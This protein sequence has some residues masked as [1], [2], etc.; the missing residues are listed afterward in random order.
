MWVDILGHLMCLTLR[1]MV[2]NTGSCLVGTLEG[3]NLYSVPLVLSLFFFSWKMAGALQFFFFL[4][5]SFFLT[6]SFR[7]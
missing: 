6:L 1:L 2:A 4:H 5:L 7:R 3:F